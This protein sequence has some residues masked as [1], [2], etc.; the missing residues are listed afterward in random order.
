LK[1]QS[2]TKSRVKPT[3]SKKMAVL[4]IFLGSSLN[5]LSNYLKKPYIFGTVREKSGVKA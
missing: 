3:W 4:S 5:F 2:G 1:G